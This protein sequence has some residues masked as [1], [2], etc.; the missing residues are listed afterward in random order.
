MS[1]AAEEE[2]RWLGAAFAALCRIES[3]TGRERA[4]ADWVAAELRAMGLVPAE[5]GCA[6]AARSDAGN[7]LA[8]IEPAA[9][10]APSIMLCA[11][12]D[13]VALAAAV[14]P[15]LRDG[16][17]ENANAGIL[18]AD[19]KAAVAVLLAAARR[20]SAAPPPV[21]V[22]LLFTVAEED[23]LRGA[24]A[25]DPSVLRSAFGYVLD[26]ASPIGEIVLASPTYY[27]IEA[28]FRGQAA[29]AGI[30]PEDGRSAIAAAATAVAAMPLGRLDADTTVNVG[31]IAGGSEST[32]V[33]PDRCRLAAE[34]RSVDPSRAEDVVAETVDRLQDGADAHGCDVD[35]QVQ[36]LFRGYR[37]RRTAPAV[38]VA[39]AALRACGHEPRPIATGGGSDANAFEAAGFSC[40]N[41]ANGTERNHEPTEAVSEAALERMLD[42]VLALP[43]AA[44]SLDGRAEVPAAGGPAE[45]AAC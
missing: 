18:G 12:L 22:E 3:P 6:A 38:E 17:W 43:A 42:V 2:R 32:N 37:T 35:V 9:P 25:F 7:L 31:S 24:T 19:N 21:G 20:W 8:R 15:V 1:R 29:H 13:T 44:A 33:V 34:V 45:A 27:R 4:C 41:L 40:V 26:H 5:D 16:R 11:H 14:E 39:A 36:C 23:G 30:R 10:G 28:E